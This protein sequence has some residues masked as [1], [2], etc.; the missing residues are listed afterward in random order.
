MALAFGGE[1]RFILRSA[2]RFLLHIGQ[3]ND[4]HEILRQATATRR[5]PW[6][7]AA[8]IAVASAANRSPR[9]A[10]LGAGVLA[11]QSD[12]A[13][14]TELASA[15][16]TLELTA[17]N[18]RAAR[19]LFRQALHSPTENSV[20]QAEWASRQ[21]IGLEISERTLA[22][23]G[24]FEARAFEARAAGAW[25]RALHEARQW[26]YDQP[27]SR[28]AASLAS[29]LASVPLE[30]YDECAEIARVGLI[31]TPRDPL[32]LNNLTFA[33]ASSGRVVEA[34]EHFREIPAGA[35]VGSVKATLLATQGLLCYRRGLLEEGRKHYLE[36]IDV[37]KGKGDAFQA[38][39]AALYFA[40]E[41]LL[42]KAPHAA[43]AWA[44]ALSTSGHRREMEIGAVRARQEHL[45]D[46]KGTEPR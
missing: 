46:Q 7:L 18:V 11:E 32:L 5:D 2:T 19:K 13:H 10:R 4:A 37:A 16:A 12:P 15:L 36:A 24:S 27:F 1:N 35:F 38:A 26:F 21:N 6:L 23:P 45:V 9:L 44:V 17:G 43:E 34:E 42:A 14:T 30:R 20:A 29:Y 33:L 25:E 8:E 39:L 40:R 28:H 3:T 31:A 22:T 41:A